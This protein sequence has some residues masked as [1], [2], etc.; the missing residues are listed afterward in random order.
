MKVKPK[1][2]ITN[3]PA[4][5]EFDD[6]H[7]ISSVLDHFNI[8]MRGKLKVEELISNTGYY[9][10]IFYLKKDKEYKLLVKEHEASNHWLGDEDEG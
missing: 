5:L 2:V 8:I 10:A 1:K 7:Q 9:Y 3:L 4:I 6:Y